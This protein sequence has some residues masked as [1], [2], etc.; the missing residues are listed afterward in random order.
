MK[1]I[2]IKAIAFLSIL[3]LILIILSKIVVPKNNTKEAGILKSR[4]RQFGVLAE[5]ENTID[6]ILTGD[7]EAY[8]S[9]IPLEA[10][11]EYGYTS[12]VCGSPG[13]KLPSVMSIL[14]DALQKQNPKIVMIETNTIYKRVSLTLPLE[15]IVAKVLPVFEYHNRWK[16]LT[17]NDFFGEVKYTNVQRDKGFYRSHTIK[18]GKNKEYMQDTSENKKIPKSNQLYLKTVKKYCDSKGIELIFY[19]SPSTVNWNRAK[20][21]GIEQLARE[22]N[23]DYIDM[24]LYRDEIKIDWKKDTRDKGDHLNYTG[25]LKATMFL[26]KYL[27]EKNLPDHRNDPNYKSWDKYYTKYLKKI[28][29]SNK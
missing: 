8:T 29:E 26:A 5:P 15:Q 25:S 27:N 14:Y 1:N 18:A 20:H 11:H 10:W 23:V 7:S 22:M 4:T 19:S 17:P 16:T 13:Q 12:Y 28:A 3:L 21:N 2:I 24:N 6:V 9:F